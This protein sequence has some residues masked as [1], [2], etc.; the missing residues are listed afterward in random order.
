M[1]QLDR[2]VIDRVCR[3][4]GG[5]E[6]E[7]C[8]KAVFAV[9]LSGLTLS[10]DD[11]GEYVANCLARYA[12]NPT[13]ICFEITE[14]AAI[15]NLE[16]ALT[17]IS[18]VRSMGA[19]VALDDF[20]AGLSSFAYLRRLDVDYLKIDALFVKNLH[21]D[22]RDYAVVRSIMEVARV[23]GIKTIAEFVHKP[24]IADVLKEMGVDFA[25]GYALHMP[26]P[27]K[28]FADRLPPDH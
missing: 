15:G 20:G 19:T 6:C 9:N 11:L 10:A 25:Q 23:H 16:R 14:T 13:R 3:I 8:R 17:F 2:W 4:I 1:P 27:L 21:T 12:A 18:R 26:E 7:L 5:G 28:E 24:V 22:A